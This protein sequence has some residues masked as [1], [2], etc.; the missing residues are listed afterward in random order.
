ME[1][2]SGP[3]IIQKKKKSHGGHHGGAWKVAYA[4][5]VTAMMALFIVLWILGQSPE[6]K[7]SVAGY[8]KDPIG[9]DKGGKLKLETKGGDAIMDLGLKSRLEQQAMER[10][11]LA[12][13]GENL[14]KELAGSPEFRDLMDQI[15]IQVVDE[16]LRIEIMESVND[17]FFGSGSSKLE[18]KTVGLLQE[19]GK[20][21]AALNNRVII[22]GHTDARPYSGSQLGY[23]NFELSAERANSA[24]R[25]MA[26]GGLKENQ[27]DEIRGYADKRLR[28]LQDP[29]DVT[30]RRISVI[31]KYSGN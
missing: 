5:F 19:I 12:E 27:I 8:F 3:V 31:V 14:E 4:D 28:N 11:A 13:M 18:P 21:L 15:S 10:K 22:E 29:Y 23:S 20:R 16:G 9:F 26:S 1:N 6:V 17:A 25:A 2:G 24:R 7:E 30:N